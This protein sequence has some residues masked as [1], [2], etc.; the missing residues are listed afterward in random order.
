MN[1]IS[2]LAKAKAKAMYKVGT[3]KLQATR[4]DY[5]Y[6]IAHR[7]GALPMLGRDTRVAQYHIQYCGRQPRNCEPHYD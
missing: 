1:L 2:L 3:K 6:R 5:Y 4:C 7:V